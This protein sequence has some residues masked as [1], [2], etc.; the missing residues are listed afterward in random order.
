MEEKYWKIDKELVERISRVSRIEL[1]DDEV[2]KFSNEL[3]SILSAFKEIDKVDTK[4]TKPS[5]HP[6]EL[7]ND[8]R[9]D[10]AEECDW[11]PMGNTEHKEDGYFKG[12][13]AV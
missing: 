6:Q 8:W 7:K 5:F 9:E 3:G 11:E 13:K 4:N 10:K 2:D 1:T 12:P